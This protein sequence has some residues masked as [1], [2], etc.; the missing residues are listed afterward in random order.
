VNP[1]SPSSH[2]DRAMVFVDGTNLLVSVFEALGV[3]VRAETASDEAYTLVAQNLT[4]PLSSLAS[5]HATTR[6][7]II[8]SYWFGAVQGSPEVIDSRRILLRRMGFE[9]ILFPQRKG[10]KGEKGVDL[11]VAREML[12]HGF[13]RNYDTAILVAGDEDYVG[14]IQDIKR[15]GMTT[16]GMFLESAALSPVLRVEVDDFWPIQVPHPADAEL[17]EALRVASSAA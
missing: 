8:R 12:V 2:L 17:I 15:M 11:A 4:R 14:L 16:V 9:A 5:P 13:N 3:S 10:G 1:Q 6:R 7:R